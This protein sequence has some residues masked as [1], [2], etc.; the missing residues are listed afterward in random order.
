MSF[1]IAP[2]NIAPTFHVTVGVPKGHGR[3]CNFLV[4]VIQLQII[5]IFVLCDF[6]VTPIVLVNASLLRK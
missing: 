4:T 3:I 6:R 5:A 2:T 1:H